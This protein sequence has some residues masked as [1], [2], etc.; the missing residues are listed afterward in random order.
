MKWLLNIYNS[1]V[2]R[3]KLEYQFKKKLK[4]AKED[5]PYIYK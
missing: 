5:D 1:I 3:I 4:E 2:N